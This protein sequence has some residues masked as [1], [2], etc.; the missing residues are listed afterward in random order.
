MPTIKER[1]EES[2]KTI[3]ELSNLYSR[4]HIKVDKLNNLILNRGSTK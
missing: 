4:L 2:E 1:L 3:S